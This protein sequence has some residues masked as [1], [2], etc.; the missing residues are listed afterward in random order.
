MSF[1]SLLN[2]T[3]TIQRQTPTVDDSGGRVEGAITETEIACRIRPLSARERAMSGAEGTDVTHRMYCAA[4][5]IS[6]ADRVVVGSTTYEVEFVNRNP[7]GSSAHHYEVDLREYRRVVSGGALAGVPVV[8]ADETYLR[9]DG[10]NANGPVDIG[11]YRLTTGGLTVG[12]VI[13]APGID[14]QTDN[15]SLAASDPGSNVAMAP[16]N[17]LTMDGDA[18]ITQVVVI[19]GV[20]LTFSKGILIG[21][22]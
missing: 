16:G 6:E 14:S 11:V 19:G 18:G 10:S 22:A 17:N 13:F 21:V 9:I 15:L 5:S 8:T 3:A 4:C 1:A 7:G 12:S 20:S 2:Q